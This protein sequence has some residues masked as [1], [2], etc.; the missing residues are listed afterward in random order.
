MAPG[1]KRFMMYVTDENFEALEE[2]ASK[3]S[4]SVAGRATGVAT[5]VLDKS[6]CYD[7]C[8]L[9]QFI[10]TGACHGL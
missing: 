8:I 7:I 10:I 4:L 6:W 9:Y 1:I 3:R 5:R 2:E